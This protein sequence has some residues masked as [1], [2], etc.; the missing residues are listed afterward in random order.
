MHR[1]HWSSE[2]IATEE[3][4]DLENDNLGSNNDDSAL[5]MHLCDLP[6][7]IIIIIF[8]YMF[9]LGAFNRGAVRYG[10]NPWLRVEDSVTS[11]P[12]DTSTVDFNLMFSLGDDIPD[13]ESTRLFG[14]YQTACLF[15]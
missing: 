14:R 9:S 8:Q 5:T 10:W 2:V 1:F 4:T 6:D 3:D 11:A 12:N 7:E 15:G 13:G